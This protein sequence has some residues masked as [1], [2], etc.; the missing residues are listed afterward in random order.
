MSVAVD[1]FERKTKRVLQILTLVSIVIYLVLICIQ[2]RYFELP[3]YTVLRKSSY[4][5]GT[6][7]I[8]V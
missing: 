7:V 6:R 5:G 3:T 4:H 8:Q 2:Q 1:R